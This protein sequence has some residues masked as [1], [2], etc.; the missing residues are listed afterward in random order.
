VASVIGRE[1]SHDLLAAAAGLDDRRLDQA[2]S[3]L[4]A[5]ELVFPRSQH[6]TGVY[7]FKHALVR[8][9][10]Y[11]SLLRGKRQQIHARIAEGRRERS[12]EG[13][14]EVLAL[15]RTEGGRTAASVGWWARPGQQAVSRAANKEAVTHFERAIAQLQKLPDTDERSRREAELQIALA[16][17]LL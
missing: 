7:S 13:P 15:N 6:P 2:L 5:A 11:G 10:A 9:A 14:P 3:H 8:D 17:A 16:S 12:R 4:A 1:F